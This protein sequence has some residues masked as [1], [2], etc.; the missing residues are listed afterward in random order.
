MASWGTGQ[1]E[2]AP[3]SACSWWTTD[4]DDVPMIAAD[5]YGNYLPGPARG[6]PQWVTATG[7]VEGNLAAPV[8][9]RPTSAMSARRS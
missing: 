8:A 6:L 7:L 2:T 4:V 5:P 3:S 1:A 9:A